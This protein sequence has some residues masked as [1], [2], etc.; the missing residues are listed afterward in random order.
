MNNSNCLNNT[1]TNM[2]QDVSQ[3]DLQDYTTGGVIKHVSPAAN[4]QTINKQTPTN[5]K[6]KPFLFQLG[7]L[8]P[9]NKNK[10][11]L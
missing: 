2:I 9:I 7:S 5:N 6:Q 10:Y 8:A 1:I 3:D 11:L 4:K